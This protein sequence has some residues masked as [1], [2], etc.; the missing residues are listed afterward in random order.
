MIN[1]YDRFVKSSCGKYAFIFDIK[2]LTASYAPSLK[3]VNTKGCFYDII[4][5]SFVCVC[6]I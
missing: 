1:S 3:T 2:F 4:S 6:V 5:F